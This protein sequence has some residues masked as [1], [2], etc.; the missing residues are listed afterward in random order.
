MAKKTTTAIPFY[1]PKLIEFT[2]SEVAEKLGITSQAVRG[3]IQ[4]G[5]FPNSYKLP[6]RTGAYL[7]TRSDL[8]NYLPVREA[9]KQRGIER[10][11]R[12]QSKTD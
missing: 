5:H 11:K 6:G 8:E 2:I 3:L 4:R 12:L 7:I 1:A 10:K 9:R